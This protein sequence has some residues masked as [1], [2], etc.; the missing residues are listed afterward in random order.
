MAVMQSCRCFARRIKRPLGSTARGEILND[1]Y[2]A[3]GCF[4]IFVLSDGQGIIAETD[5][6]ESS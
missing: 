1:F 2:F 6:H 5:R 3:W 4:R